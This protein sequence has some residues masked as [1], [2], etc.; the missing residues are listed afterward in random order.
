MPGQEKP[1]RGFLTDKGREALVERGVVRDKDRAVDQFVDN[2][3]RDAP[4]SGAE[5]GLRHGVIEPAECRVGRHG[6]HAGVETVGPER[7][8]LDLGVLL[9]KEA[10]VGELAHEQE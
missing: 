8:G 2:G 3:F 10:L 9:L 7:C 4:V 6:R 1:N 5:H